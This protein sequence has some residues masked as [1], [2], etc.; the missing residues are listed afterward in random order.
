M[1]ESLTT[2]ELVTMPLYGYADADYLAGVSRGT[3]RRWLSGYTY[4]RVDGQKT[5]QPPVAHAPDADHA[6]V[7]FIDLVEVIAIGG[8]KSA[9]FSLRGIRLVVENCQVILEVPRPLT[10]LRFKTDGR[11][12]FVDRGDVLLEIGR[13]KRNQAW[14]EFLD[15]FL[16]TLDYTNDLA[17]RWW[18]MG[19]QGP[20][21]VDPAFGYGLP[22]IA[23]SG[24]RTEI[25]LERFRA[26]DLE[27]Q[28]A[29]DFNLKPVEVERALQFELQ[30][31]A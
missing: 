18:P 31:A 10:T 1:A 30:R 9:G 21:M 8:L 14:T 26:G 28:I 27:Q 15:P 24:V 13:R 22:V 29:E 4:A 3:A 19:K 6:A 17:S 12:I 5:V 16:R 23:G 2:R 7:S 20:I 11:E 25:I